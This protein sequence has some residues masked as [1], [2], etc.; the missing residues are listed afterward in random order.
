MMTVNHS[1][2]AEKPV[3]SYCARSAFG[4]Q[5][6]RGVNELGIVV[7]FQRNDK[8]ALSAPRINVALAHSRVNA[9]LA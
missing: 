6:V 4:W 2:V 5:D 1:L 9:G 7:E 8:N 3:R